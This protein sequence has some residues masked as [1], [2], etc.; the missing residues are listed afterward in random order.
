MS[1]KWLL[2]TLLKEAGERGVTT[3]ELL[4]AGVGSRY[5]ARLLELREDG[6]VI[7]SIRERAGSFRYR[8]LATPED[9]VDQPGVEGGHGSADDGVAPRGAASEGLMNPQHAVPALSAEALFEVPVERVPHW[10]AA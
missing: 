2:S 5:G 9:L 8:L 1:R 7:E 3:G 10:K 6:Y 4:Q